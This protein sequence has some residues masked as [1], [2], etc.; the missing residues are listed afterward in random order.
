[1]KITQ[2]TYCYIQNF[3]AEAIVKAFQ[4]FKD[5]NAEVI[6]MELMNGVYNEPIVRFMIGREIET[7]GFLEKEGVIKDGDI[8]YWFD[9]DNAYNL[10]RPNDKISYERWCKIKASDK[11]VG[12]NFGEPWK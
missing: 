8:V 10:N 2:V 4:N 5:D 6:D 9:R 11:N 3:T 7:K 1:M 12:S